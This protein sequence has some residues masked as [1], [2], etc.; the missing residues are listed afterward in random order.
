MIVQTPHGKGHFGWKGRMG[1]GIAAYRENV[2]LAMQ[3]WLNRSFGVMIG[4]GP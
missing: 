4:V 3:K 1:P 2:A